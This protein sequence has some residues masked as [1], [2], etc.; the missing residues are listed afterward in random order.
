MALI[1]DNRNPNEPGVHAILI[2]VGS[3]PYM[4]PDHPLGQFA[5]EAGLEDLESPLQ[6]IEALAAW[7][8]TDLDVPDTPLRSL[9]VLGSSPTRTSPLSVGTTTF[10]NIQREIRAWFDDVDTHE[11][12][13]A[14]FYFVG[15]GL[16][17]G[18]KQAL[19][20]EDFGSDRHAPFERS[21]DPDQFASAVRK[22][23]AQ[24]QLFLID[25]CSREVPLGR[26][27]E[28]VNPRPIIQAEKHANLSRVKQSF[29]RASAFGTRAF[30]RRTGPSLF[31]DAFLQA[32]RGGAAVRMGGGHWMVQTDMLRT[33]LSR[34]IEQS[35]DGQGQEVSFGGINLSSI[36]YFHKLP[37][38]PLVPVEV[39]CDPED[40]QRLADLHIDAAQHCS[41]GAWPQIVELVKGEHDFSAI[42]TL[43]AVVH[44]TAAKEYI[45]PPFGVVSIPCGETS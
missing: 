1:F 36:L 45:H 19:L 29:L 6:S 17:A 33:V 44:G 20:A 31:M 15:H 42:E 12:N 14:I 13:L 21:L 8:S 38:E 28:S 34:L 7:L 10:Q 40:F 4:R 9:R 16:A 3:Y 41:A 25:S 26:D 18:A 35:P 2:G 23:K 27:F 32:M 11:G 24:R 22:A 5:P 37:G 39:T 30:G 43:T